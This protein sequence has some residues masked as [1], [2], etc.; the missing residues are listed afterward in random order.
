MCY[1]LQKVLDLAAE[2][3]CRRETRTSAKTLQK[4]EAP[5]ANSLISM[6]GKWTRR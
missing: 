3:L 6:A 4:T 2:L 5:K 1:Q